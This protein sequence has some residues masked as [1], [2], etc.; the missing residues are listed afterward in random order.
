VLV[1]NWTASLDTA[2]SIARIS[3]WIHRQLPELAMQAR[4]L[5]AA[6]LTS[7][8]LRTIVRR[9]TVLTEDGKPRPELANLIAELA[10][11]VALLGKQVDDRDLTGASRSVFEDIARRL[12][13]TAIVPDPELRDSLVVVLMRPRA[14]LPPI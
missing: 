4:V 5:K 7:R 1:D 10:N 9:V 14:L 11:G 6:D 2:T 3:P 8:H 13:P 12:D